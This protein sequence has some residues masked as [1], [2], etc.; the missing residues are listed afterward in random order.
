ML[1]TWQRQPPHCVD[2]ELFPTLWRPLQ[3]LAKNL[4]N[5]EPRKQVCGRHGIWTAN[6][7]S[8]LEILDQNYKNGQAHKKLCKSVW[9]IENRNGNPDNRGD[10]QQTDRDNKD[11]STWK[12]AGLL[13]IQR[14][15]AQRDKTEKINRCFE[16]RSSHCTNPN[17][18]RWNLGNRHEK[19]VE[20]KIDKTIRL[21]NGSNRGAFVAETN[22]NRRKL[23]ICAKSA[24]TWKAD[25]PKSAGNVWTFGN[26]TAQDLYR[27]CE[28]L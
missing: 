7:P 18:Q 1:H 9:E 16:T 19:P 15:L 14:K 5:F 2:H 27:H 26:R 17:R 28:S 21:R 8:L 25:K 4:D 20:Q 11:A 22:P 6:W 3:H 13:K 10:R 24:R 12:K 23:L